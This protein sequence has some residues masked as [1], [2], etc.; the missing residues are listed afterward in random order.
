MPVNFYGETKLAGEKAVL[1]VPAAS[2]VVLRVPVLYATDQTLLAESASLVVASVLQSTEPKKVD[3][4]G[5]RFPTQGDER[6]CCLW[7][8]G[9][10]WCGW[11]AAGSVR[12]CSHAHI[13]GRI[14][15]KRA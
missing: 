7:E 11:M 15:M 5:V 3:D 8:E 2:P 4:W 9:S 1:A 13:E 6:C 14:R 12:G 10:G